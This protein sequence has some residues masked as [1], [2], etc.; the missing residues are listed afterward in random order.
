LYEQEFRNF[1]FETGTPT[2]LINRMKAEG[3][4]IHESIN[5]LVKESAFNKYDIGNI[6]ITAIMFQT[7]YLTV[8]QFHREEGK[9]LLEY[10]NKEVRDSFLDFAVEQYADSST[11]EMG[12]TVDSLLEALE[13]NALQDFFT[14]LQAL[15]SSIAVKQLEKVK[16][17]EGFYHSIIYIVLKMLGVRISC[18]IQ[19]NFGSTDAVIT[20]AEIIYVLEFKMGAAQ[21]ALEQIKKRRYYAPYLAGRRK[22]VIV[23][24]GMNKAKRNLEDILFETV[25]KRH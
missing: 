24:L 9:Y 12:Y 4:K 5:K 3:K 15:F 17:Y 1:W 21:T 16:E 20:T 19:S 25:E 18:E 10:P 11:D 8:K 13:Q 2:F 6:N 7:G 14:A 22:V 23:G